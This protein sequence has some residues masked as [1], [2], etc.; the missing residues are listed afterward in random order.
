MVASGAAASVVRFELRVAG[1]AVSI[2]QGAASTGMSVSSRV[3]HALPGSGCAIWAGN[4]A[5]SVGRSS[6]TASMDV[7]SGVVRRFPGGQM[8]LDACHGV[9]Q[10]IG[11]EAVKLQ[12]KTQALNEDT[13]NAKLQAG[14]ERVEALKLETAARLAEVLT[15]HE[16]LAE[17]KTAEAVQR[18]QQL[19]AEAVQRMHQLKPEL[20]ELNMS[21]PELNVS[22]N[23]LKPE[24][25]KIADAIHSQKR[26]ASIRMRRTQD[27]AD[28]LMRS[29]YAWTHDSASSLP[30]VVCTMVETL[31]KELREL[32]A[33][34]AR[35]R[36]WLP[37]LE[38]YC[39]MV[40]SSVCDGVITFRSRVAERADVG[41]THQRSAVD[42][43]SFDG[44]RRLSS[45]E[46]MG[47]T[48]EAPSSELE[49]LVGDA[50]GV[51]LRSF[52]PRDPL[53]SLTRRRISAPL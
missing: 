37:A 40:V 53:N 10:V 2:T 6:C 28:A 42:V 49:E 33:E 21:L 23:H 46:M 38:A 50:A 9:L 22:L 48:G 25:D 47:S 8:T 11:V 27:Q 16:R 44:E 24:L 34:R 14:T 45:P 43:A 4:Q 20:P 12:E 31:Q 18:M 17:Q 36:G 52:S 26:G 3:F 32:R 29:L 15:R 5:A 41:G 35:R 51:G 7:T 39:R 1:S 30:A 19:N 13:L